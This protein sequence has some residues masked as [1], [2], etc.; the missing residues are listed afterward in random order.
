MSKYIFEISWEIANKVGGIYT[1]LASKA[2]YVKN[3]YGKNYFVVGPYFNENRLNDFR[4]LKPP[5][6][7]INVIERL[8]SYG[9]NVYYGEWLIDGIPHGFLIDFT[10]YLEQ[11][12]NLKYELWQKFGVDSLRT[13]QDYNEPI[14][15]SK[16][17]SDFLFELVKEAD[18]QNSILHF[19]E[20][21]AGGGLIFA[22]D[23]KQRK[24]FTTHATVLG[25]SLSSAKV[26]FWENIEKFEP[27]KTAYDYGVEAKHSIEKL[28]ANFADHL[29]TVSQITAIEVEHFLERK[30]SHILPNGIDLDRFPT[31]EEIST[32][33]QKNKNIILQFVLYLF[34]PYFQKHCPTRDALIFFMSGREEVRNKGF[35]I[36]I[37]S[38]GKLNKFLKENNITT[39]IYLF[40]FVPSQIIDIDHNILENLIVYRSVEDYLENIQNEIN[41]RLLHA[42]IHQRQI[43]GEK[44]LTRNEYL[45]IQKMLSK[46]KKATKIPLATHLLPETNPFLDLARKADLLNR[47]EDK[48]K[49][50][51][52]PTYVSSSDGLLNLDYYN[53]INGCHLGIFPSLYEPWG[54]TPL[55]TLAAGVMAIT[56]DLTGFGSYVID[57]QLVKDSNPGLWILKRKERK[58]SEVIDD[59]FKILLKITLM[60]RSERIQNKYE[61]RALATN[62][63]WQNLI[64]NYYDL[65]EL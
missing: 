30:V 33:H 8:R 51:I 61:A 37:L 16:A 27:L 6:E 3:L 19:H 54:Y 23:L 49:I 34:S 53:V 44:I 36:A 13:G 22:K 21:L 2:K 9:I 10:K 60:K 63:D 26:N 56:T 35:D 41:S 15:W 31:F 18:F 64:K 42:L 52:Y 62:F 38:L 28:A 20:W 65:Y 4:V 45:E 58:D 17:V 32:F 11:I 25:R 39:N 59:L 1:V 55:E 50:I 40:I 47:E 43:E 14:A 12:N 7:F 46:I 57:K 5:T 29:T 48:V 24:I